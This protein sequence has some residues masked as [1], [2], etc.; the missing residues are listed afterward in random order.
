MWWCVVDEDSSGRGNKRNSVRY[1]F[2]H[3]RVQQAASCLFNNEE[4]RAK[5]HYALGFKMWGEQ[6]TT[7]EDQQ[8]LFVNANHLLKGLRF[9]Q[10]HEQ[11]EVCE[12]FLR[13]GRHAREGMSCVYAQKY[14][15]AIIGD[16]YFFFF[17]L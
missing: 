9:I 1:R 8:K 11:L 14:L 16:A 5:A 7:Q 10:P 12:M 17:D 3:D 6:K 4:E 13:A 2:L 15:S